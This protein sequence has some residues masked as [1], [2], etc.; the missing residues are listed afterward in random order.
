MAKYDVQGGFFVE[1]P[2][3]PTPT[4]PAS[5]LNPPASWYSNAQG[6]SGTPAQIP[7]NGNYIFTYLNV[8]NFGDRKIC[9]ISD[10]V[11][12]VENTT[13]SP[14]EAQAQIGVSNPSEDEYPLGGAYHG[15]LHSEC[16]GKILPNSR[17]ALHVIRLDVS[18]L[19]PPWTMKL[20]A[21]G[22]NY[23]RLAPQVLGPAGTRVVNCA[24]RVFITG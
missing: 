1:I 14:I 18:R 11:C 4:P 8:P 21:D 2:D 10:F 20:G 15:V 6:P 9:L 7:A 23:P 12:E 13:N 16:K 3:A 22:K 24:T 17:V 19:D 5:A